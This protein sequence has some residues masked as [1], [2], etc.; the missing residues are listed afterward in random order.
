MNW[1]VEAITRP[2]FGLA[3][4]I[5][6]VI[7]ILEYQNARAL[8]VANRW[9]VHT[10]EVLSE[11]EVTLSTVKDAER[12]RRGYVM[13]GD[14]RELVPYFASQS[15]LPVRIRHLKELTADNPHQQQRLD[16]LEALMAAKMATLQESIEI[17]KTKGL[18]AASQTLLTE[19]GTEVMDQ[20]RDAIA[21][22]E[23]EER[24]LL[25]VRNKASETGARTV[26][27]VLSL[28]SISALVLLALAFCML[29]LQMAARRRAELKVRGL[30]E[31]APDAMVVVDRDGRI[32][33]VNAQVERLFGYRREELLGQQ[34]EML[35]PERFR[36]RHAEHRT[37]FFAEPRVRTMG[38][39]LELYGLHKDDH[40]FPV[41]ISLSPLETEEGVLVSSAIRDITERK[42][43]EAS[44]EQ[45]ASIVDYS[46]DAIV[47]KT[48][49]GTILNWNKGAE[50]LYGYTV[51]EVIG[52]PISLLLP[53]DRADELPA[54]IERLRRGENIDHEE[55]V[56]QRKDGRLIDVSITISPIKDALGR[57]IGASTIAHDIG[58]RKRAEAK[59]RDLLEAAPDAMVVVGRTGT[60]VLVNAQVEKLFGYRREELLGQQM[61]ILVPQRLR[62]RHPGHRA[63]FF[64]QP[65][66]R[67]MGAGLELY[68][69]R[70]DG[71]EFPVEISLS[72][73][74]T[75]EGTLVS[76]AI[77]D[78][79]ERKRAEDAI[80]R[81]NEGVERR[82]IE[83]AAANQDLEAFTYS[84]A[85][86]L[87]APVRQVHGFS[88]VLVEDFGPKLHAQ[89]REYL[90]D[91]LEASE[92]MGR[93]VDDLLNLARLGRQKPSLT[94][95][96]LKSLLD[97]VLEDLKSETKD[98]DIQ[99]HLGEL[100][101]VDCDPA[102][103][104][105]VFVNL[106]SNAIKYTRPRRPA[107]IEVGKVTVDSQPT[108][109][110]RDNGVGFDM[111][112]ADKLFGVFQRLHRRE[113]FEGTGVGLASVQRIIHKHGGRIW[114]EAELD[115]G[116][117]FYFSLGAPDRPE[118]EISPILISEIK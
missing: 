102:L 13:T 89:A 81:L 80:R 3:V 105:Q 18:D 40:E 107:V 83:L 59:F 86:D 104:K 110:V 44:R 38:A 31:A 87:R 100:P 30:L 101:F 10:Y 22:M 17:R 60:I 53:L 91:I 4:A 16:K 52:K 57:V 70:K 41:E 58:D 67:P 48:L 51:Q 43:A 68:A 78:V 62:G 93:L 20:I 49:Q 113:D 29:N 34:V 109:F 85:H 95:T 115:K 75:E 99:W 63:G 106:L 24:G 19:R 45:L 71:T 73:L 2:A 97:E 21:R 36:G 28:G 25:E 112:Y 118:S 79:T 1:K 65:R 5:L 69:L 108:V 88:Q 37:S 15:E 12:G 42:R 46:D 84:V 116:A 55:T 9:V 61:E 98:R 14:E 54:I 23:A 82:N 114:A 11:L 92:T 32:V 56:R 26:I 103:M 39:G 94:V 8:V 33:L 74:E 76:S 50:R 47:G 72:P 64:A 111:K 90:Q 7:S 117:T 66:V 6:L 35:V 96:G 77:R 27:R